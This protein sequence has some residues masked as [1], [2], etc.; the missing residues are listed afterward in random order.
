V[1][2][3]PIVLAAFVGPVQASVS[4][5]LDEKVWIRGSSNC[6]DNRDPALEVHRFDADTY[7]LRQNKCLNFE[8]PFIYV[9]FGRQKAFVLDTGAT[10][11]PHDFPLYETIR[12]LV[13]HGDHRA[14]DA[15][16]RG[17]PGVT[18]V[19]PDAN[20]VRKYFGFPTWPHGSSRIDLG[21]RLL[22][23]IPAPGHQDE[24]IAVYDS[25][26]GWLLTGDNLY[27]GRLYV[28]NWNEFRSSIARL[29]DFSKSRPISAVLGA[30]IE[31][32]SSGSLFEAGSTFQ[33]DEASLAL[34]SE[35]LSRLDQVLR[36]TGDDPREIVT[37]KFVVVPIGAFQR[38]LSDVLGWFRD[39]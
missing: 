35:D 17:K 9:L 3:W 20:A 27:P 26:T 34:A 31:M 32:S 13:S 19:E 38:A 23:V 25:R 24:G 33:P 15:Q 12:S 7:I 29:V 21:D 5:G 4:S 14:A 2:W 36:D 10:A 28:R 11:D 22:E 39:L 18:L 8:A 30:H 16:F 1:K 6:T 37:S